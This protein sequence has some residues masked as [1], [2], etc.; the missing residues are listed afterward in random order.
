M[1]TTNIPYSRWERRKGAFVIHKDEAVKVKPTL[2]QRLK[3]WTKKTQVEFKRQYAIFDNEGHF[4]LIDDIKKAHVLK[5]DTAVEL[6]KKINTHKVR[7]SMV[8][9]IGNEF[10]L[11]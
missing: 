2:F 6:A 10:I 3:F 9:R 7:V 5:F 11:V 4:D 8:K 1:G